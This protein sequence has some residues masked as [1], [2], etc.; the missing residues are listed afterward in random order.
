VRDPYG[1]VVTWETNHPDE[2]GMNEMFE[3]P[4]RPQHIAVHLMQ[5]WHCDCSAFSI[6]EK[7]ISSYGN[8][9]S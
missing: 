3:E 7:E 4:S 2:T 9:R 8:D 6:Q 1:Q 5:E